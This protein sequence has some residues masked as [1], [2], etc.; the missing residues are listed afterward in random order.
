MGIKNNIKAFLIAA[1]AVLSFIFGILAGR[2][3]YDRLR[4]IRRINADIDGLRDRESAT[5]KQLDE[6]IREN[7]EV[8]R[9]VRDSLDRISNQADKIKRANDIVGELRRR[10]EAE[11]LLDG[12]D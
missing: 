3:R 9:T 12:A 2:K 10:R 11:D 1:G 5:K 4:T 6:S 7:R 8:D